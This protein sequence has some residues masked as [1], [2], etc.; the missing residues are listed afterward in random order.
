[1]QQSFAKIQNVFTY[2]II[3]LLNRMFVFYFI[4][5]YKVYKYQKYHNIEQCRQ[6]LRKN[7]IKDYIKNTVDIFHNIS[8]R[9]LLYN[10][11][12]YN[13]KSK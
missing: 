13:F 8:A 11:Y 3:Q 6:I 12:D 2:R 1:M 4:I 9:R 5:F 7:Y 10:I